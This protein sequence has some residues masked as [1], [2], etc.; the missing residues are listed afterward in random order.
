VINLQIAHQDLSLVEISLLEVY[1]EDK[2]SKL[3]MKKISP[4]INLQ[5]HHHHHLSKHHSDKNKDY[6][7]LQAYLDLKQQLSLLDYL[8]QKRHHLIKSLLKLQQTTKLLLYL[9]IKLSRG[10]IHK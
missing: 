7:P 5:S 8:A 3:P 1:S 10:L 9:V 6:H 4:L 2:N